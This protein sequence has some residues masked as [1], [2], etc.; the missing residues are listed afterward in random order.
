MSVPH[1]RELKGPQGSE[2][3]PWLTASKKAGTS[4]LQPQRTEF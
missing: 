1:G 3:G 2:N 4:E